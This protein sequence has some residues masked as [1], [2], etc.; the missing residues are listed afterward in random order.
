MSFSSSQFK[1]FAVAAALAADAKKGA[2]ISVLDLRRARAVLSDF[3]LLMSANSHV[4]MRTLK[5]SIEESLEGYGLT[6]AHRDGRSNSQWTALD[7][8]GLMVHI[9]LDEA[10]GFYSLERLWPEAKSVS[11]APAKKNSRRRH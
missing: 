9:F 6:P 5:D 4:H 8:G 2:E 1:K 11:W 3:L 10:R 7:Y